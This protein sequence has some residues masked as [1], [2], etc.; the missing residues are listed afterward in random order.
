M[1]L[2]LQ[3]H[4]HNP[5]F[6]LEVSGQLIITFCQSNIH[7]WAVLFYLHSVP[8]FLSWEAIK[9]CSSVNSSNWSWWTSYSVSLIVVVPY[10]P[11]TN[12]D[13]LWVTLIYTSTAASGIG[14]L[15][16][17]VTITKWKSFH[18]IAF[19]LL[20]LNRSTCFPQVS[21]SQNSDIDL[22]YCCVQ[23]CSSLYKPLT[24]GFPSGNLVSGGSRLSHLFIFF[25]KFSAEFGSERWLCV[26]A[27]E[28]LCIA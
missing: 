26:S 18:C 21:T 7:F 28:T 16:L 20:W 8:F 22:W 13:L 27:A 24:A 1:H 23:A 3:G 11:A 9:N 10:R 17:Y 25:Y 6:L 5:G 2:W 14:I 19:L 15:P 4:W 12:C